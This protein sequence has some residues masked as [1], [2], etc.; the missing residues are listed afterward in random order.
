MHETIRRRLRAFAAVGLFFIASPCPGDVVVVSNRTEAG[1]TVSTKWGA[2]AAKQ[3]RLLPQTSRPIFFT[4]P[5]E[6]RAEQ[7]GSSRRFPVEAGRAYYFARPNDG[8]ELQLLQI[9]LNESSPP[10]RLGPFEG[11]YDDPVVVSVKLYLDEDEPLRREVWEPRLRQRLATASAVF[12]RHA[13][14]RL[15]IAGIERW[16]SDDQTRD[17]SRTLREFE[18]E[19]DAGD[20]RVAIGFSSQYRVQTGRFHLGGTRGSLHSHILIKERAPNVLETERRELLVHELGHCLGASHSPEPESVMRPL[21]SGKVQRRAGAVIKFDPVNTLLIA[22]MSDELRRRPIKRLSHVSPATRRRMIEIYSAL[23]PTLP[24]D[25]AAGRYQQLVKAAGARSLKTDVRKVADRL[26]RFAA[27]QSPPPA[28]G[29][30]DGDLLLQS[31][32]REAARGALAIDNGNGPRAFVLA[33]GLAVDD[34]GMLRRMQTTEKVARLL[35]NNLQMQ[36][37]LAAVGRPTMHGRGDLAKHFFISAHLTA[38]LGSRAAR[39]A[40]LAK[41]LVDARGGT[42]FSFA[43]MAANRA[44]IVFATAVLGGKLPLERVAK[45]F[46]VA[47]VLPPLDDLRE[48]LDAQTLEFEYGGVDD[49]RFATEMQ[50]IERAIQSLPVYSDAALR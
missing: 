14:I 37:R 29:E 33:M 31:Y 11:N 44:G 27:K 23:Q 36:R 10:L 42:G 39:G 4:G 24:D 30:F 12:E 46:E 19:V 16:D 40:G 38:A 8:N 2:A 28:S 45:K 35:E 15:K 43:D 17:F 3:F 5:L 26:N 25:P 49:P 9:G 34:T 6:L 47:S 41:E 32:V 22:M 13:G 18:R 50:R 21:I 7:S 20:A 1:V 48:G